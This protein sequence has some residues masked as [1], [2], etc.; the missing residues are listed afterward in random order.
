MATSLPGRYEGRLDLG[1]GKYEVLTHGR[2]RTVSGADRAARKVIAAC[3]KSGEGDQIVVVSLPSPI[4]FG[5]D[6]E[7]IE[8]PPTVLAKIWDI[9]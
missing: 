8:R 9:D 5:D 4:D 2:H 1:N 6:G 7:V 3:Q